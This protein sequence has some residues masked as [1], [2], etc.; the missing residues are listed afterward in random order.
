[1]W[2]KKSPKRLPKAFNRAATPSREISAYRSLAANGGTFKLLREKPSVRAR[3]LSVS[4]CSS[5]A[6]A[7]TRGYMEEENRKKRRTKRKRKPLQTLK[8]LEAA[9]E[10]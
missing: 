2:A 10:K 7:S 5:G 4:P 8:T 3:V 9:S 6:R 1:M